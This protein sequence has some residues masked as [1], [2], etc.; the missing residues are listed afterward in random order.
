M[1]AAG[2]IGLGIQT[3]DQK[4]VDINPVDGFLVFFP[5]CTFTGPVAGWDHANR[6]THLVP[7]VQFV[8]RSAGSWRCTHAPAYNLIP[9]KEKTAYF[10]WGVI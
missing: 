2:A 3:V 1:P 10:I 4:P 9:T 7:P 6:F 8:F 5:D